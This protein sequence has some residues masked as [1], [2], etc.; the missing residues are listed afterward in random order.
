M[1]FYLGPAP[2]ECNRL[3]PP[4][5]LRSEHERLL[6][7]IRNYGPPPEPFA[8]PDR[9]PERNGWDSVVSVISWL[10]LGAFVLLAAGAIWRQWL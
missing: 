8:P 9:T 3:E 2:P 7:G 5:W 6:L 4:P 1:G 10:T